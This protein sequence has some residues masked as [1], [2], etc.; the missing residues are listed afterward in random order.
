MHKSKRRER[1]LARTLAL[2]MCAGR[3]RTAALTADA[4]NLQTDF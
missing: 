1:L 4:D 3:L 2:F